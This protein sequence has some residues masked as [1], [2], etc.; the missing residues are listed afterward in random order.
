MV[1][2][3]LIILGASITTTGDPIP[4]LGVLFAGK[5]VSD[6]DDSLDSHRVIT[7]SFRFRALFMLRLD[8]KVG[9]AR[10]IVEVEEK[11][12]AIR[13]LAKASR[14]LCDWDNIFVVLTEWSVLD[15]VL[16]SS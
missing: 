8:C 15:E 9:F 5:F 12:N 3:V 6:D 7:L 1:A 10:G 16:A 13:G 14:I 11:D 4:S 2:A